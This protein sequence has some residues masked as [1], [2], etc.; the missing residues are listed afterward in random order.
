MDV[1]AI[2]HRFMYMTV[3]TGNVCTAEVLL[4]AVPAIMHLTV[5]IDMALVVVNVFGVGV[6]LSDAVATMVQTIFI[7]DSCTCIAMHT[8]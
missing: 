2:M 1:P 4:M 7:N 8:R 5:F 3:T 6:R